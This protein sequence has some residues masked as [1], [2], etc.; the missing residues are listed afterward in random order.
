[1]Q[2]EAGGS[3][4]WSASIGEGTAHSATIAAPDFGLWGYAPCELPFDGPDAPH[5]FLEALLGMAVG[6]LDGF[7]SF[8]QILGMTQLVRYGRQGLCH[9]R[10]D[11]GLLS[12]MT[13]TMGT[14]RACCTSW[15]SFTRSSWV[16]DGKLRARST[17][18]GK[19]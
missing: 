17:S 1:M 7:S 16:A 2:R 15:K 6:L 13:P 9:G 18:L 11:G 14:W 4:R 5:P 12:E 8:L 19:K 10:P 3:H